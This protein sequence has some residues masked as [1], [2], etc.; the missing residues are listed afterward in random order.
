MMNIKSLTFLLIVGVFRNGGDTRA[1]MFIDIGSV[2][3]IGVPM[4]ALFG[5]VFHAPLVIT[6]GVMCTEELVKV[7]VALFRFKSKKWIKNL[8][9]V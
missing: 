7:V 3:L 9:S 1:A 5:L 6:Y 4:V 8:V 2:W